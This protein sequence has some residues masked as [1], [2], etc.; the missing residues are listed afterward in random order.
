MKSIKLA[1][2]ITKNENVLSSE[3]DGDIVMMNIES[4]KYVSMNAVGSEIW[5]MLENESVSV[6]QVSE[7]LIKLFNVGQEQ[8]EKET[9]TFCS[10]LFE[11]NLI[12][13]S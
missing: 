13:V 10:K 8:C 5:K 4:G 1:N 9:L 3:I 7:N 11:E 6:N 2:V 12:T